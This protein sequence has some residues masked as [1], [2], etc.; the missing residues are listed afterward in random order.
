[1][2]LRIAYILD[3]AIAYEHYTIRISHRVKFANG[4]SVSIQASSM[5]NCVPRTTESSYR[6]Y[7][8]VELGFPTDCEIP[9]SIH[10]RAEDQEKKT[11]TVYPQSTC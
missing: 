4:G 6:K 8:A 5:H 2:D 3:H 7:Q 1:M 10:V 9:V 11:E